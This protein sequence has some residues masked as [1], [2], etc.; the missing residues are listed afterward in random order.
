[1]QV[2]FER[3]GNVTQLRLWGCRFWC[4]DAIPGETIA[5]SGI[6]QFH[7]SKR[8]ASIVGIMSGQ[9]LGWGSN[10]QCISTLATRSNYAFKR[11]AGRGFDVS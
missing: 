7:L 3:I 1:L 4:L 2:P 9:S 5:F 8:R 11:T 6:C 10:E